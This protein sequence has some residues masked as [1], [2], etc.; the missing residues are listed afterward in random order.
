MS[1]L[2]HRQTLVI[3]LALLLTSTFL[4]CGGTQRQNIEGTVTFDGEPVEAGSIKL[5]P[6][7]ETKGPSGGAL[8]ENGR[9]SI[10]KGKG[11]FAGT[12]RVE[13]LATKET[14]RQQKD[15]M[16]EIIK[17]R[18][19]YIPLKYNNESTLTQ[20]INDGANKLTFDLTP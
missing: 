4:G 9:F 8:I 12:F 7:K 2:F 6:I 11:V 15:V 13:I 5:I 17:E 16:G 20:E 19:Q 14:G 3:F 10:P 18:V 1:F